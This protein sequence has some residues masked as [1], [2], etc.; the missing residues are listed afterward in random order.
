M[1]TYLAL[2]D[3]ISI[4]D[5]TGV[6]GGGAPSQLARKLGLELVD[7]TRDG[8]TTH[9]VLADLARA[10]AAADVVTL[11]AGGNDLLAGDLPRAIVRRLHEIADRLEPLGGRVLVNTI[12]DPSDGDNDVGRRELGLSRLA[13]VELRRRLTAVNRGIAELA[14]E[15]RFVVADLEALFHGHGIASNEPWFVNVI[16]PNLAGAT[17]TADYWFELLTASGLSASHAR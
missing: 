6:P 9:G 11:T 16:E 14:V 15:H 10:P 8:N 2:G 13:A 4:D 1:H 7:L 3:S 12:Y 5:Y 17:A